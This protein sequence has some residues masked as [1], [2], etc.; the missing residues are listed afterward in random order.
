MIAR[1]ISPKQL[2]VFRELLRGK[3]VLDLGNEASPFLAAEFAR[4]AARWVVAGRAPPRLHAPLPSS[5]SV[6]THPYDAVTR[7]QLNAEDFDILLFPFPPLKGT[8]EAACLEDAGLNQVVVVFGLPDPDTSCGSLR[9]WQ[10]AEAFER[11]RDDSDA[12]SRMLMMRR[13]RPEDDAEEVHSPMDGVEGRKYPRK[14]D[15]YRLAP[16]FRWPGKKPGERPPI[17]EITRD[18]TRAAGPA[19]AVGLGEVWRIRKSDLGQTL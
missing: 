10:L 5:V 3:R 16:S 18:W 7:T 2:E 13:P 8:Q 19:K 9:F 11:V 4:Y 17:V 15:R 6:N 1:R 14:G 12:F